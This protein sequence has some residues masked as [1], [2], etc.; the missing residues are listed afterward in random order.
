MNSSLPDLDETDCR[1]LQ[2]LQDDGR[3]SNARLAERLHL[4]ETPVWRRMRRLEENG[5]IE[6]YQA[7]LNKKKLGIG[8]T[9][10]VQID[11]ANHTGEQVS[12]FE[13]A[14]QSIPE[15]L[16]CHNISGDSD[17][18]LHVLARDLDSY[19]NFVAQVLRKLPGVKAIHSSL[20]MREVKASSK[21]PIG[22][23]LKPRI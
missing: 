17:Y 2:L 9:A 22:L 8:L 11:F 12:Q 5:F 4:S 1:I 7:A 15:I 16:S 21:I 3:L 14:I 20:S 10:F 18:M 23:E 6:G 19:G 13:D